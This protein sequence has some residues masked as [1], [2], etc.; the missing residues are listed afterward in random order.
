[1]ELFLYSFKK[2]KTKKKT[3]PLTCLTLRGFCKSQTEGDTFFSPRPDWRGPWN[4]CLHPWQV[5][6]NVSS[7][8]LFLCYSILYDISISSLVPNSCMW[9]F[10]VV[11]DLWVKALIFC[12]WKELHL[13]VLSGSVFL[14]WVKPAASYIIIKDFFFSLGQTG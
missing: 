4:F 10:E 1:M 11:G 13:M 9:G 5:F 14:F 6:G 3:N 2:P 12:E 7:S 8:L